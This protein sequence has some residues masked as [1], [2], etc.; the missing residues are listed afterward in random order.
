MKPPLWIAVLCLLPLAACSSSGTPAVQQTPSS[1]S[2]SAQTTTTAPASAAAST[3]GTSQSTHTTAPETTAAAV[4]GRW[5]GQCAT[6]L[7][8]P[9]WYELTKG[10]VSCKDTVAS[11]LVGASMTCRGATLVDFAGGY[12]GVKGQ[13]MHKGT[14]PPILYAGCSP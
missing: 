8:R 7:P 9:D 3:A 13:S 14:M 5:N 2:V 10:D 12:W 6:L 4:L 1:P 11:T